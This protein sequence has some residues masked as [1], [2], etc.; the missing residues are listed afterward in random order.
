MSDT[1]LNINVKNQLIILLRMSN[2]MSIMKYKWELDKIC[3]QYKIPLIEIPKD[4]AIND[5]RER[6][7]EYIIKHLD[8]VY[9]R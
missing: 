5:I 6:L 9:A 4:S 3:K 7:A 1:K 8:P 2:N